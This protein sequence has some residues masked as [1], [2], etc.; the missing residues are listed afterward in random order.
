MCDTHVL[1]RAVH[2]GHG[3]GEP[4]KRAKPVAD[5]WAVGKAAMGLAVDWVVS[6]CLGLV[7]E[8]SSLS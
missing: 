5:D 3:G 1:A 4:G 2:E 6:V 8:D 7:L